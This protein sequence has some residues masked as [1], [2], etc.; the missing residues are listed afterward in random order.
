MFL[1]DNLS[2]FCGWFTHQ[3]GS[4]NTLLTRR[5]VFCFHGSIGKFLPR[6]FYPRRDFPENGA[7]NFARNIQVLGIILICPDDSISSLARDGGH[8]GVLVAIVMVF[9]E[10]MDSWSWSKPPCSR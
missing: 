3:T 8:V 6:K 2:F 7:P 5:V 9:S 4:G 1:L 10:Q